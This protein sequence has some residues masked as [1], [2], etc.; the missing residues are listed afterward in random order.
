MSTGSEFRSL[1]ARLTENFYAWER[2]GRGWLVWDEPV[3]LEPPFRPFF[4]AVAS[5]APVDDAR[6][7]GLIERLL[8]RLRRF[9]GG[10]SPHDAPLDA[11]D[12]GEQTDEPEL[13]LD[14]DEIVEIQVRLPPDLDVSRE[15]A[16]RMVLACAGALGPVGFELVG[17]RG[18]IVLQFACRAADAGAVRRMLDAFVPD[19]TVEEVPHLLASAWEG[20]GGECVV[21]D[22]G[23]SRE[24]M[25]PLDVPRSFGIDPLI[26]LAGALD[27][28]RE[29]EVALYQVLFQRTADPWVESI[30]RA[31]SDGDGGA[32][33]ADAPGVL[34]LAKGKV[35]RPLFAC[36]IRAGASAQSSQRAW[37]LV[38]HLGSALQQFASPAGNELIPLANDGYPDESHVDD[39]LRRRTRRSGMILAADE[40]AS[41]AHLPSPSVRT[42]AFR[43]PV[44]KTKAAPAHLLVGDVA[45]GENAHRGASNTIRLASAIR[46]RHAHVIGATGSGKSTLLRELMR[47]DIE[48]GR[49]FALL[50][51]HGDLADEVL[52]L[53]PDKRRDDVVVFDPAD[54]VAPVG[55]N[56][57]R[58]RTD[59][60]KEL[61]GSDL[62]AVFRRFS[63]SWG[64]QMTAVLGNAILALLEHPDG[65]TLLDLRRFLVERGF[66][67]QVLARVDDPAV[68]SFWAREFSLLKGMP[69][70]SILTRLDQFLRPRAVRRV[71]AERENKLDLAALMDRGGIFV[72]KLS[73]GAIGE[74]NAHLL[75]SLLV[76][77]FHQVAL[78]R[79]RTPEADR[80]DFFLYL[81]EF[82]HFV[83]PSLVA[84]LAGAR[85]Y[86]VGLVLAH[87]ELRQLGDR[88]LESA[89]LTNAATRVCFRL[90][91]EDARRL[92]DGFA[93]FDARDLQ[94]L[95]TGEAI[96]RVERA[97]HDFT[98]R[99]RGSPPIAASDAAART[100]AIRVRSRERWGTPRAEID[101]V[102]EAVY[103]D[104]APLPKE[105][106]RGEP[107]KAVNGV[108]RE[109]P[110]HVPEPP[111]VDTHAPREATKP[112][113]DATPRRAPRARVEPDPGRGGAKH[114]YLQSLIKRYAEE[115]GYRARIEAELPGGGRVDVLLDRG[116]QSIACE[117]SIS[118]TP[119]QELANVLKCLAGGCASVVVVSP[120]RKRLRQVETLASTSL[121]AADGA[122]VSY[123]TPEELLAFL[124]E[125][126]TVPDPREGVVLGYRV[127]TS[128]ASVSPEDQAARQ[129]SIARTIVRSLRRMR[130]SR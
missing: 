40:V 114:K 1:A 22:F 73:Q 74:E 99:V 61:L 39:L 82:H 35:S 124:D 32:F 48:G 121:A 12:D 65:G 122:K 127:K 90:G 57:L 113:P 105:P 91:D 45:L 108:V 24:F 8:D 112:A 13:D 29:G 19:A 20:A 100:D 69:Q 28:L 5:A 31:V 55:F 49:G 80:R 106:V 11:P 76:A 102:L 43:T 54:E 2:R 42:A 93:E 7:P 14:E 27:G 88:E 47:Q 77:K 66:R 71:V 21:V 75:G 51:P 101:R 41:I 94:S 50:D 18:R 87:Q 58:A 110:T 117:I 119:E 44:R 83:T 115:R 15:L 70:A 81:D 123:R 84:L 10:A 59:R 98:I 97:D 85:K 107:E 86:H 52:A 33:F 92:A 60:E 26:A 34:A 128:F 9:R 56:V 95:A 3:E 37:D 109:E 126:P 62:V 79:E 4:H 125:E 16:E 116:S 72:G 30:E 129:E 53:I 36:V 25:L 103:R 111:R 38:R 63:T 96:C 64:D 120:V 68:R 17:T 89:L 46:L 6:T 118:S 130:E 67:E 23:L 78:S 104:S